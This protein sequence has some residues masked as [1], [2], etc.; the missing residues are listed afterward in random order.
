MHLHSFKL[1]LPWTPQIQISFAQYETELP[2]QSQFP[3]HHNKMSKTWMSHPNLRIDNSLESICG[4]ITGAAELVNCFVTSPSMWSRP[5][6]C[7]FQVSYI[8]HYSLPNR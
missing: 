3:E 8:M 2:E 6:T 7:P 5:T 1:P 4:Y